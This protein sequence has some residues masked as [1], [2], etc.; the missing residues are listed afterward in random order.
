MPETFFRVTNTVA[1]AAWMALLLFPGRRAVSGLW[2]A[3]VV[4]ACLAFAYVC[5]LGWKLAAGGAEHADPTTLAGLR[6]LFADDWILAAAWTH[7]LVFD[8][9]VGAWIARDAVRLGLPWPLRTVA[10]LL[11]FLAG[12]VGFLLHVVARGTL[13]GVADAD[14]LPATP[15][16]AGADSR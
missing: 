6:A 1:L 9:V 13:R 15:N 16:H 11:T 8:M 3:V 7:Y 4:P 5:V 2:V 12:P 14:A 10:L